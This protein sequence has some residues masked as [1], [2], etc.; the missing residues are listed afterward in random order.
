MENFA[1]QREKRAALARR[2]KTMYTCKRTNSAIILNQGEETV[3]FG[4]IGKKYEETA[5]IKLI[6][7]GL[8]IG[9]IIALTMPA[10]VPV[11]SILGDL[12]VKALKGVAPILVF[13]LVMNA[14]AQKNADASDSMKPIV[15]LYV[16]GT[17]LASLVAVSASFLFP[18]TLHLQIADA[19]IAPPS[20]IVEV[21]KNLIMNV[22]D[23]PIHA[24]AS[25]NYIGILSWAV[26]AGIA[27]HSSQD[28]TKQFMQDI[29]NA[30]TQI[31]KWII[32]F[33][34]FGIM[35]LVADAVGARPDRRRRGTGDGEARERTGRRPCGQGGGDAR[36][37]VPG[38][39][40]KHT[41]DGATG[42]REDDDSA[43]DDGGR[44]RGR[45]RRFGPLHL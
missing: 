23:N 1:L 30:I 36:V 42:A 32:R 20:G 9:I 25:A 29:A 11:V 41:A 21:L 12:F 14:M 8:I 24:L 43:A 26:L 33:A 28:S 34:P 3:L 27:L 13:V 2:F 10:A 6:A 40:C 17:F 31:V 38:A 44:R 15:G 39:V 4:S 19:K 5:L 18:T 7:I 16:V 37:A 22:V 45:G 35:G